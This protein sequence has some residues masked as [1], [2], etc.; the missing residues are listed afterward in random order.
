MTKS[1]LLKIEIG[2]LGFLL[3]KGLIFPLLHSERNKSFKL[4]ILI[5]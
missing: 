5:T 3:G 2:A 1:L 4:I